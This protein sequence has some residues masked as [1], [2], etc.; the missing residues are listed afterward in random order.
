[1]RHP[2]H[3]L[4]VSSEQSEMESTDNAAN[5]SLELPK[6]GLSVR[7]KLLFLLLICFGCLLTVEVVLRLIP[8]TVLG[9]RYVGGDFFAPDEFTLH[10]AMN[11]RL[12]HDKVHDLKEPNTA[13][14]ILL[15]DSYVQAQSVPIPQ[16]VGQRLGIT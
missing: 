9:Y 3:L 13:R 1:M 5:T 14:V 16:I 8:P 4:I 11:L 7:K 2:T 12:F 10:T 15:G 6:P